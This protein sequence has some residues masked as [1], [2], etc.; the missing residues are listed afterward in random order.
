MKRR[1]T[2]TLSLLLAGALQIMPL[3]RSVL[4]TVQGL[5]P[6]TWAIIFRWG[7]GAAAMF[8][9]HAI[10]SASSI[11]IS[12]PTATVGQ[13]Y[14]GT[15]T[16]SGG[17]AGAVASMKLSQTIWTNG[18]VS[19]TNSS[20]NACLGTSTFMTNGL[21]I[22]YSGNNLASIS[23]TP[24]N[25]G[26]LT[27]TLKIFD[28]SGC[29]GGNSDTR[30]T[31]LIVN[32]S[33]GGGVAPNIT[34]AP[35]SLVTQVGADALFSAG[36]SGN[37]APNY[38]WY[39]GLPSG[40]NVVST[41]NTLHIA[42]VQTANAGLYS[43]VASNSSGTAG[44]LSP[45][46]CYLSVC[47]TPGT[48][49]LSYNY[50]NFYPAGTTLVL[51]SFITNTP[52]ATNNYT[53]QYNNAANAALGHSN[54]ATIPAASVRPSASGI[55]GVSFVSALSSSGTV[56]VDG[57]N[58]G[59]YPSYWA[60]GLPPTILAAPVST[61]V[62]SGVNVTLT[63][64]ATNNSTAYGANTVT[65]F[66]WYFNTTN[67]LS[68]Q[69]ITGLVGT[70]S[71]QLNGV[72]SANAGNYTMVSTNFWGSTTS[73]PAALTITSTGT[74]PGI[75]AQPL[76]QSVLV[77]QNA[78]FSVTA[79]GTAP[80]SYQWQK[81]GLGNLS[82][83]GI[84]SGVNTNLLKLTGVGLGDAGSYL[85]VITNVA[86]TTNSSTLA[87]SVSPPPSVSLTA[88]GANSGQLSATT[89]PGINYVVEG[90]TNLSP[91]NWVPLQTN[92]APGNGVVLFT[93]T[94]ANPA[95]F[96]RLFFP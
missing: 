80:L 66:K 9:Y 27:I 91:A 88:V 87:L 72:T 46:T 4:P 54:T 16:Y 2:H 60:F 58:N 65:G 95:Q 56:I 17:H 84:Y 20:Y 85:V 74:A 13:P 30:T 7:C 40:N 55:Y 8:G 21:F 82:N 43:V 94:T 89:I 77:G 90:S 33:G 53:W 78:S 5:A 63:A 45:I 51:S 93:N 28:G 42:S 75:S 1:L 71:L 29:G 6:S 68:S 22:V 61:N 3:V 47:V 34:A 57:V 83:G 44:L 50:T 64:T 18:A 81:I 49:Q 52:S 86:G 35:Q 48:N 62:S 36:A 32:P 37:P 73:S 96:F 10:S 59:L 15:V 70:V 69:T 26:N 67:F 24:T 25:S 12:P 23:G 79:T 11:A 14:V 31:T 38:Y 41:S 39:L 76:P 19:V 92:V